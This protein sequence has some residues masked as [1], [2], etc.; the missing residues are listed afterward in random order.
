MRETKC[1]YLLITSNILY[2][3]IFTMYTA[4]FTFKIISQPHPFELVRYVS[5]NNLD[6]I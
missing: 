2:N 1:L 4:I 3:C 6:R 5:N